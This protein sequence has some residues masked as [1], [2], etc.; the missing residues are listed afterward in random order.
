M[1]AGSRE[2]GAGSRESST[3]KRG[4]LLTISANIV[5]RD[6]TSIGQEY[7]GEPSSTS[8]ALEGRRCSS[9][10]VVI[11]CISAVSPVPQGDDLVCVNPYGDAEGPGQP[12]VGN[13][14]GAVLVD[15]Q[16]LGLQV[17]AKDES[18]NLLFIVD[19]HITKGR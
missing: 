4:L 19:I 3:W 5:P 8:G 15:Q 17:P 12:E 11:Q 14:D 13:L 7:L 16:V 1:Y 9:L 10:A 2:Q 6:Q 18:R